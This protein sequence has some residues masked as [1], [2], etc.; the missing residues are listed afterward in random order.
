MSMYKKSGKHIT[1]FGNTIYQWM[2]PYCYSLDEIVDIP[3]PHESAMTS[4]MFGYS[5]PYTN[6]IKRLTFETPNGKPLVAKWKGQTIDLFTY[7]GYGF[8]SLYVSETITLE[9][10]VKNDITY[11][12]LKNTENWWTTNREYSRYNHDSAVETINSLPDTSAY[13]AT[14]GGTNTIRFNKISGNKT[15]GGAIGNL[16]AEEIAVATAKGWTVG[17]S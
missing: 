7:V 2:A 12:A 11:Q 15:D 9:D 10:E 5:F 3:I 14:A 16:T 4:N 1:Y 13:L 8:T 6:R 17:L